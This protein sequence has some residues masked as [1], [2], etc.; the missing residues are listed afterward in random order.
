[1]C[2]GATNADQSIRRVVLHAGRLTRMKSQTEN[3]QWE[4]FVL[5]Y[6]GSLVATKRLFELDNVMSPAPAAVLPP[7]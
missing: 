4:E 5:V 1:M 3:E 2:P 6:S 7:P